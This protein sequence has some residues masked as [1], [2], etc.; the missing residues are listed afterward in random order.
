[1]RHLIAIAVLTVCA[2]D[3]TAQI[4]LPIPVQRQRDSTGA[5]TVKVPPFRVEPPI[6]PLGALGRSMLVPGWGQSMLRRRVTGAYFVFWEGI[7]LTM[8]LKAKHQ[9]GYLED[10]GAPERVEAKRQEIQDW[11]VL[12]V[13]NHLVAGAEAYVSAMLWDFP[14]ELEARALPAGRTGMGFRIPVP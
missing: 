6:S 13:F 12:L 4:P 14:V 2:G 5:D 8:V 7:T 1:M 11:V 9:L 10:I 3:V